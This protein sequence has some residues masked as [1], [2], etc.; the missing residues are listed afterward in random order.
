MLRQNEPYTNLDVSLMDAYQLY[1][2]FFLGTFAP[3]FRASE[4]PIAIA[5]LRLVTFLPLRPL[6]NLPCVISCISV[7]TCFAADDPYLRADF[8]A[9]DFFAAL[10][11]LFFAAFLVAMN[12]P[13]DIQG[14]PPHASGTDFWIDD[15]WSGSDSVFDPRPFSCLGG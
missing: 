15:G 4:R 10:A 3:F 13:F 2:D 12:L 11:G 7:F 8:F 14:Q 6:F 9:A 5:C 1:D